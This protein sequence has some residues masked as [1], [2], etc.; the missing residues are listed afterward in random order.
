M[1]AEQTEPKRS[2]IDIMLE[3]HREVY[4]L[5]EPPEGA[6]WLSK[7]PEELTEA[8]KKAQWDFAMKC[9][10]VIAT[11]PTWIPEDHPRYA[12]YEAAE[13]EYESWFRIKPIDLLREFDI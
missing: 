3:I 2:P 9:Q 11:S 6:P 10:M 7:A 12:E 4:P 8:D 5:P 1:P 13:R